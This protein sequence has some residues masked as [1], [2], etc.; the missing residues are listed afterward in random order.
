MSEVLRR[1]RSPLTLADGSRYG[2]ASTRG[3]PYGS[4]SVNV[5]CGRQAG[6]RLGFFSAVSRLLAARASRS[7]GSRMLCRLIISLSVVGFSPSSRAASFCTPPVDSRV[8]SIRR[9]SK[10]AMTSLRLIPSGGTVRCGTWKLGAAAHVVGDELA[11]DLGRGGEHDAAL[12]DVLELAHVARPVVVHQRPAAPRG[13]TPRT[14]LS[15][16]CAYLL[17]EVL[18]QGRDVL[19][20]LAQRRAAGRR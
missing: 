12:D 11:A 2:S 7:R 18:D 6:C 15:F 17:D 8:D 9:R 14:A 3:Q 1:V 20:A 19:L 13:V 4:A 5:R 10:F 16:S